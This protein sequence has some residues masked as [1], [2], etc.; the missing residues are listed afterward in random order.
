MQKGI[1]S[2][3]VQVCLELNSENKQREIS[4]L[5]EAMK[6]FN[7][8]DG[9]IVTLSQNDSFVQN[10]MKIKVIPFHQFV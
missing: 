5:F 9:T 3:A 2:A 6:K 4:G 10:G 1:I 8:Q 7:L